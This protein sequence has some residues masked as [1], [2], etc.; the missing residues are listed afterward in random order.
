M[1]RKDNNPNG[2]CY[3]SKWGHPIIRNTALNARGKIATHV[4]DGSQ[5]F[6]VFLILY[7]TIERMSL[8]VFSLN[9]PGEKS[10]QV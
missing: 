9:L 3:G 1:N 2:H 4:K 5:N 10:P 7:H 6:L 8:L